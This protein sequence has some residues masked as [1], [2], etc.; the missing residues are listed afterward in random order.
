MIWQEK[1]TAGFNYTAHTCHT[2]L[3]SNLNVT[4]SCPQFQAMTTCTA[5]KNDLN[6]TVHECSMRVSDNIEY[7][8]YL[9]ANH[10]RCQLR[11]KE[12]K[13]KPRLSSKYL[14]CADVLRYASV[15]FVSTT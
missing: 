4:N 9:S 6:I 5:T 8:V 12:V 11:G 3:M 1:N 13:I 2:S 7:T 10:L 14:K 15:T